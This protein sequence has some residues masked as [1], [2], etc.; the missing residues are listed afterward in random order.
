MTAIEQQVCDKRRIE[1]IAAY[2]KLKKR[3]VVMK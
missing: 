1:A 3:P 2:R